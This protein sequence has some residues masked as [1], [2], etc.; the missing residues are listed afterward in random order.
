[1]KRIL[2]TF[3]VLAAGL[4][5]L[6]P[7]INAQSNDSNARAAQRQKNMETWKQDMAKFKEK[8]HEDHQLNELADS[9]A[10][11]QAIAAIRN[12][13]FVLEADNVTFR[14]GNTVLVNSNTNFIS[15]K[16]NR[17]VVQ[18]SPSNFSAGPNGLGGV[19]VDG[20]ISNQKVMTDS[21]GRVTFSMN[22]TGIGINAEVEIYMYP[23]SNKATATVYPN[24]NSNTVWLQGS[25]VPYNNS[26]VFEGSSL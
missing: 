8:I 12:K 6:A 9:I 19:T 20:Y 18:I 11:I 3:M 15:V 4:T 16:G 22:V 21:K 10:S 13:D 2:T 23:D 5:M 26:N 14:N 7:A 1:M 24:F 17:A 25:I